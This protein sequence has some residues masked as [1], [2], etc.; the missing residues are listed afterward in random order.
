MRKKKR[1]GSKEAQPGPDDD[2]VQRLVR[3]VRAGPDQSLR[4]TNP[5]MRLMNKEIRAGRAEVSPAQRA[6]L[7]WHTATCP[8]CK[9]EALWEWLKE[10]LP[11]VGIP[12]E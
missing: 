4:C 6:E 2:L 7:V 9:E 1:R 5:W 3:F 10:E 8:F 11:N 12:I